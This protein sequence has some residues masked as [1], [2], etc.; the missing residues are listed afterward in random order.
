MSVITAQASEQPI[1]FS[2]G[3]RIHNFSNSIPTLAWLGLA[4]GQEVVLLM[5]IK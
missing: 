5:F 4:K 2:L 3:L 1:R